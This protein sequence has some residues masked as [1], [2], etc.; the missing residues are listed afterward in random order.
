MG[1]SDPETETLG[2]KQEDDG[3]S[4]ACV[5]RQMPMGNFGGAA[6]VETQACLRDERLL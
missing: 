1:C 3:K 6:R 2:K 5:H 4:E